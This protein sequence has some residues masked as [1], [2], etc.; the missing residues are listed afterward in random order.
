MSEK[1][2]LEAVIQLHE[3]R[4]AELVDLAEHTAINLAKTHGK[5]TSPDVVKELRA[6][7]FGEALDSV[8]RRFLGAVFRRQ[9][10]E[11]IGFESKG[12]HMRPV[13]VWKRKGA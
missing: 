12:S 8:D 11:R 3:E 9:G 5:V 7:G 13:T 6:K 1:R 2:K 4:R 10:W